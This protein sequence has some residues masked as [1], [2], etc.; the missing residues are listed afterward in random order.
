VKDVVRGTGTSVR[1]ELYADGLNG[2]DPQ[3]QEMLPVGPASGTPE[4]H[5][6]G[7]SVPAARPAADYCP[8]MMPHSAGAAVPLEAAQ[9]LWQR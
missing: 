4:R 2:G 7:A 3:R 8:R 9:L 1:V 5:V 6:Y